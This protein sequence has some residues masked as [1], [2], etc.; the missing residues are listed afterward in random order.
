MGPFAVSDM[1]G[2]DIA[3]RMRKSLAATRD[4][5][6]RYVDI[7]DRLCEQG[8]FGRK[9][10]AG[11]YR[12]AAGSKG[13]RARSDV[14]ALIDASRSGTTASR[15]VTWRPRRSSA[16]RLLAMV[17]EAALLLGEGVADAPTD[18]D[19]VL[20]N[21]YGFPRWEG[22]AVFWARQRG[23]PLLETRPRLAG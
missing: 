15:R 8:R 13:K 3:W 2:L 10:G 21:G 9:T 18:V 20:V 12:Y 5:A 6:Q 19:V 11:C 17:N 22:G 7:A 23:R 16:A 1:S 4:P 14:R